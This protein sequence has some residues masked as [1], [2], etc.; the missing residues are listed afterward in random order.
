MPSAGELCF[1]GGLY[2]RGAVVTAFPVLARMLSDLGIARTRL[3]SMAIACASVDDICAWSLLAVAI[4]VVKLHH[5]DSAIPTFAGIVLF[6]AAML[7]VGRWLAAR[8]MRRF[9]AGA[10]SVPPG[11]SRRSLSRCCSRPMRR[12]GSASM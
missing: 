9:A 4:A 7:T 12:K 8:L 2:R 1:A 3:G 5:I 11:S 6:A 10:S